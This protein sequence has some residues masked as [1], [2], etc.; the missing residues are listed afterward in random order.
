MMKRLQYHTTA[1]K[2]LAPLTSVLEP[3]AEAEAAEAAL[4]GWK[5]K[6]KRFLKI[7][8]RRKRKRL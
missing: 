1:A 8:W 5:R 7:I 4:F 2:N 3:E 6:R